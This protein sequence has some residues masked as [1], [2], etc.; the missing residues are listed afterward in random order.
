MQNEINLEE[1]NDKIQEL[2]DTLRLKSILIHK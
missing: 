1:A 2:N